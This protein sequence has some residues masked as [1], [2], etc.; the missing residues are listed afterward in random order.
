MLL[1]MYIFLN[2]Q[3]YNDQFWAA[4]REILFSS[5]DDIWTVRIDY[6]K[7]KRF[8]YIKPGI[9]IFIQNI[10]MKNY[11]KQLIVY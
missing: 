5:P 8:F 6:N 4:C 2:Y 10:E 7:E 9:K 3:S 1:H 11:L